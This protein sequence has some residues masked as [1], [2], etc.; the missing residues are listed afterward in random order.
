MATSL[1]IFPG[2][3]MCATLSSRSNHQIA[4]QRP[5]PSESHRRTSPGRSPQLRAAIPEAQAEDRG[6]GLAGEA[7]GM[8]VTQNVLK[9]VGAGSEL[10]Q[11][12]PFSPATPRVRRR[13]R[14]LSR[15]TGSRGPGAAGLAGSRAQAGAQSNSNSNSDSRRLKKIKH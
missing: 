15:T 5:N 12:R 14:P 13:G 1:G 10:N 3:G 11:P 9:K 7:G 6:R 8:R 2:V 4:N